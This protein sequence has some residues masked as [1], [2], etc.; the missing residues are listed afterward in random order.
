MANKPINV[1]MPENMAAYVEQEVRSGDFASTSD[2]IRILIREH[3]K[4]DVESW[5]DSLIEQR[6]ASASYEENLAAQEDFEREIL[7]RKVTDPAN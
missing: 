7:G 3:Q 5:A 6:L 4:R 2:F 1:S